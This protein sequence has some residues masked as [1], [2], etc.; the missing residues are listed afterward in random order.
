MVLE[1][2]RGI[3]KSVEFSF[4]ALKILNKISLAGGGKKCG[5]LKVYKKLFCSISLNFH[6]HISDFVFPFMNIKI[7]QIEHHDLKF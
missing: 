4:N 6:S 1:K 5:I 7:F 3:A 2:M